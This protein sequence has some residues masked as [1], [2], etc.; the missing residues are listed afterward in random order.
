MPPDK[1]RTVEGWIE[2]LKD[3]FTVNSAVARQRAK[4]RKYT[5]AH[6]DV[7]KYYYDKSQLLRSAN[8]RI[9]DREIIDEIW[10]GLPSEFLVLLN[11]DDVVSL[12]LHKFGH[13]L[14]DKDMNFRQTWR[15][16]E[17]QREPEWE[18]R[19]ER[20]SERRAFRQSFNE[21]GEKRGEQSRRRED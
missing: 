15:R 18:S 19:S 11:H 12:P 3:E 16:S 20:R 4:D 6:S 17:R 9:S 10:L 5:H 14:R 1:M 21:P 13:L 7:M 2:C 8:E